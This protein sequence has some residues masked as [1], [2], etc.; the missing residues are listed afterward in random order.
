MALELSMLGVVVDD[1]N[2]AVQ[3]YR[4]L[5]LAIPE[6]SEDQGHVEIP[7]SGMTLFFNA[8]EFHRRIDPAWNPRSGYRMLP[9]FQLHSR[10]TVDSMY[11]RLLALGY[12]TH[13]APYEPVPSLYV[14]MIDD[15]DGNTVVLSADERLPIRSRRDHADT[16]SDHDVQ[17]TSR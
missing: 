9:E 3:F 11:A 7:M 5:G 12:R 15:P 14:A 1:M 10:E 4:Q 2:E 17:P 6:G 8:A 13:R 16:S